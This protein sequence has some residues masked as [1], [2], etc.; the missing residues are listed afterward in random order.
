[1]V[2]ACDRIE[3]TATPARQLTCETIYRLPDELY[4]L[5]HVFNKNKNIKCKTCYFSMRMR[6]STA[7]IFN[8]DPI[9][10]LMSIS[11]ISGAMV[12]SAEIR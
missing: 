3:N 11:A 4:D 8:M 12:T 7:V 2:R 5:D 9:S 1:M 10:G 6:V